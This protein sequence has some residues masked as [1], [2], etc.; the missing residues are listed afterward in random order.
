MRWLRAAALLVAMSLPGAQA[1][2]VGA[3]Q[4]LRKADLQHTLASSVGLATAS[5]S[6]AR[7]RSSSASRR[8]AH[9]TRV[10]A[11]ESV[12]ALASNALGSS[13][14]S[15]AAAAASALSSAAAAAATAARAATLAHA[16]AAAGARTIEAVDAHVGDLPAMSV[17]LTR[18]SVDNG[19]HVAFLMKL[20]AVQ[21]SLFDP[22]T[23]VSMIDEADGGAG[24]AALKLQTVNQKHL[25][26]FFGEITIGESNPP[27]KFRV[28]F[29]TGSSE[30][31]IPSV[32][33]S[34]KTDEK[35]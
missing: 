15:G 25:A 20:K 10:G 8:V 32:G 13:S 26:T 21:A 17:P 3:D 9:A 28:M 18:S 19:A 35:R 1:T 14:G 11:H 24:D 4:G 33:C 34:K 22:D 30:F 23:E 12:A 2:T 29:D 7:R 16:D 6:L 31:W 5:E 27:Q